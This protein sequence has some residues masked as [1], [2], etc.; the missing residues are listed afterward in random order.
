[1]SSDATS[2]DVAEAEREL[3]RD[4]T[5]TVRLLTEALPLLRPA[6]EELWRE[7]WDHRT[8]MLERLR[9]LVR[10]HLTWEERGTPLYDDAHAAL[11]KAVWE[12][13]RAHIMTHPMLTEAE[14]RAALTGETESM[15]QL[16]EQSRLIRLEHD[17]EYH[18][19]TLQFDTTNGRIHPLVSDANRELDA[20]NDPWGV[21]AWWTQGH[22]RIGGDCPADV[23]DPS[24]EPHPHIVS[25]YPRASE[26]RAAEVIRAL[27]DDISCDSY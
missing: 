1:M 9:L 14:A 3:L 11:R 26:E 24:W 19:P 10:R 7:C 6:N 12:E 21:T 4:L 8:V 16:H 27:L 15:E 17:G 25:Y 13:A 23:L 22:G 20:L 2:A 18:Y 5:A